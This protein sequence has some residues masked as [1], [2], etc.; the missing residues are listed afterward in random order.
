MTVSHYT[1]GD[2]SAPELADNGRHSVGAAKTDF[3]TDQRLFALH[4][5]LLAFAFIVLMP[6]GIAGIR[7][8]HHRSYTMH[9]TIQIMSVLTSMF[10]IILGISMSWKS[11][12]V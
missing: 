9:W 6:L 1:T 11:F 3:W 10:A 5:L 7:S 8:K 2:P 12:E 4:G